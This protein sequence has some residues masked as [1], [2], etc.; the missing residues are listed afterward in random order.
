MI[1]FILSCLWFIGAS[2]ANHYLYNDFVLGV[3]F[4]PAIM[5][6][7]LVCGGL[8][9]GLNGLKVFEYKEAP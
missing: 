2:L 4:W 7:S 1:G 6:N 3:M 8:Y 5:V 9:L